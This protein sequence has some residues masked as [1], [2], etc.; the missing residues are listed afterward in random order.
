MSTPILAT[1]FYIHSPRPSEWIANCER[2]VAWLSLDEGDSNPARFLAYLVAALPTLAPNMGAGV[3]AL[4]NSQEPPSTESIRAG[5]KLGGI[6]S[7]PNQKD[8][9]LLK[10]LIQADKI[11][12]VIDKCYPLS[13]TSEA[14]RYLGTGHARGKIGITIQQKHQI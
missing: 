3:L 11:K 12:P 2:P 1:K 8:R 14:L 5:K 10:E 6:V 13:E 9:T 4:L 7:N